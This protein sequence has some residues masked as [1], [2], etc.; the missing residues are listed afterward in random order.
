MLVK[1]RSNHAAMPSGDDGV[2]PNKQAGM[3]VQGPATRR[4]AANDNWLLYVHELIKDRK[5][6]LPTF[7]FGRQ[8]QCSRESVGT[9][10]SILAAV[11]DR[12]R[13]TNT[14]SGPSQADTIHLAAF[15]KV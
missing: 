6:K 3:A 2:F 15:R 11:D 10:G 9:K 1:E 13:A 5:N 14:D 4:L 12:P 7:S 8:Y